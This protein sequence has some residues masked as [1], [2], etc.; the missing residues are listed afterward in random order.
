NCKHAVI[1]D[2]LA[3]INVIVKINILDEVKIIPSLYK[4][5][6]DKLKCNIPQ[7]YVINNKASDIIIDN[8]PDIN[9]ENV[10]YKLSL[11]EYTNIIK[12]I[13]LKVN[14]IPT[15]KYFKDVPYNDAMEG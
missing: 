14:K 3:N 13:G 5:D 1:H 8:I 11:I 10:E 9:D 15:E 12:I 6:G 2:A 7:K 4:G